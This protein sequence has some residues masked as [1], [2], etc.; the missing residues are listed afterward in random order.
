MLLICG[1]SVLLGP[2][3]TRIRGIVR[4]LGG[5]DAAS[6]RSLV[7][8]TGLLRLARARYNTSPPRI[9][10]YGRFGGHRDHRRVLNVLVSS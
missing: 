9:Y 4:C 10:V 5:R 6:N 3:D 2:F 8:T 7:S 1:E